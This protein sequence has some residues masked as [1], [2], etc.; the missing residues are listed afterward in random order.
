MI[1]IHVDFKRLVRTN[2]EPTLQVYSGGRGGSI[3][4]SVQEVLSITVYMDPRA[5]LLVVASRARTG[6]DW[7]HENNK[8]SRETR[9]DYG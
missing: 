7:T 4:I 2:P 9:L 5:L 8:E 6:L 3:C 1:I